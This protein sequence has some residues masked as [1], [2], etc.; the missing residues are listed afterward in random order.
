MHIRSSFT[1]SLAATAAL[2]LVAAPAGASTTDATGVGTAVTSSVPLL[3]EALDTTVH[4]GQTDMSATNDE[5]VKAGGPWSGAVLTL[6]E[7]AEQKF[8][9][10]AV[11]SDGTTSSDGLAEEQTVA[12]LGTLGAEVANL[13]AVASDATNSA[14]TGLATLTSDATVLDDLGLGLGLEATITDVLAA[15]D[16]NGA[17]ATHSLALAGI[18]LDLAALLG[19]VLEQLPLADL[20]DLADALGV[21]APVSLDDIDALV[22][23]TEDLV[24][25]VAAVATAATDVDEAADALIATDGGTLAELQAVLDDAEAITVDPLD[26][27][28]AVTAIQAVLNDAALPGDCST[29]IDPLAPADALTGLVNCLEGEITEHLASLNG[30]ADDVV[31]AVTAYAAAIQAVTD[32]ATAADA[33]SEG[34]LVTD[35]LDDITALLEGLLAADLVGL[36]PL[37]VTQQVR[38]VGDD[39]DGSIANH[40]CNVTTLTPPVGDAVEIADCDGTN[41]DLAGVVTTITTTLQTVLDTVGGVEVGDVSLELFGTVEDTVTEA[42]GVVT[43][44]SVLEV[45][46]LTVPDVTITPCDIGD[47]LVCELG[48][49]LDGTLD[50]VTGG[51][52][53]T[54]DDALTTVSGA[55]DQTLTDSSETV[56]SLLDELGDTL[57]DTIPTATVSDIVSTIVDVLSGLIDGLDDTSLGTLTEAVTLDG[58]RV[59]VDPTLSAEHQLVA[60]SADPNPAPG[61]PAAPA[62]PAPSD[63]SDTPNLPNTGGGAALFALLALGGAAFLWRRREA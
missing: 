35:V 58:A 57:P 33:A 14:S 2:L 52:Q 20:L 49:G 1:R 5:S 47:G 26:L 12:G 22:A 15:V 37:Q 4:L 6:V 27:P 51:L 43:A 38:A 3:V 31:T 53:T 23:A 36:S 59:V 61:T 34:G 48:L 62:D 32:A 16:D 45:L 56:T 44:T 29:T 30:A 40:T 18:D 55:L 7:V 60:A 50:D 10:V 24:T 21:D 41:A 8:G 63:P 17:A 9:E 13:F 42:D 11:A 54:L 46:S 39:A 28:G 25:A 19:D